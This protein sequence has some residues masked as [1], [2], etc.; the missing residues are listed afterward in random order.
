M[1]NGLL[2]SCGIGAHGQLGHSNTMNY[3]VPKLVK[4]LSDRYILDVSCGIHH[5]VVLDD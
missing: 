1:N 4:G 2:Y 3:K 5:A